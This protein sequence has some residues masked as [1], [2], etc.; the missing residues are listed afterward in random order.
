[1]NKRTLEQ[2]IPPQLTSSAKWM[3]VS[4]LTPAYLCLITAKINHTPIFWKSEI[5]GRA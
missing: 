1:M 4:T 3:C 2:D 5:L